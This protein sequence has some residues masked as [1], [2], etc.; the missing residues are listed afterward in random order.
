[1]EDMKEVKSGEKAAAAPPAIPGIAP[2][3][4]RMGSL[5]DRFEET[6]RF[7]VQ[8]K[9]DGCLKNFLRAHPT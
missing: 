5:Q 3:Q 7:G 8:R 1:M 2:F 4:I 9:A 6:P